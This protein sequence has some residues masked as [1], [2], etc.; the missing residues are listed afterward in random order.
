MKGRAYTGKL[1]NLIRQ[2]PERADWWIEQER[3][4]GA[5]FIKNITYEH[6]K[7]IALNQKEF[8]FGNEPEFDCFC[9][10]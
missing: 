3:K 7:H 6:L 2:Q 10:G 1:V 9:G 4:A 8:D 5:T